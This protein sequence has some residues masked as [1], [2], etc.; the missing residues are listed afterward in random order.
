MDLSATE[1]S[2]IISSEDNAI[3]SESVSL[4]CGSG[5]NTFS[6]I[7]WYKNGQEL[8]AFANTTHLEMNAE[9]IDNLTGVY[10][11]FGEGSGGVSSITTRV[12]SYCEPPCILHS[13]YLLFVM[14]VLGDMYSH[15]L[16]T[17]RVLQS[18]NQPEV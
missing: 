5:G 8:V 10:Q 16:Y 13:H 12:F 17:C 1:E 3:L 14:Y 11:C 4:T 18:S 7:Y 6:S 15:S 2:Y 9:H